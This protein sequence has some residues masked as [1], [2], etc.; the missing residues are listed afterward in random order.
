MA[1]K[2]EDVDEGLL[3]LFE[4]Q[5]HSPNHP[6]LNSMTNTT[7]TQYQDQSPPDGQEGGENRPNNTNV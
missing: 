6:T 3:E 5:T 7:P 4:G 1:F 2:P